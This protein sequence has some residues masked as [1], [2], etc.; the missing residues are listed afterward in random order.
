M[1]SHRQQQISRVEFWN[2]IKPDPN[3]I[4]GLGRGAQGFT[5]RSDI[6]PSKF[7]PTVSQSAPKEEDPAAHQEFDQF[8]GNDAGAF[9]YGDYDEEDKEADQVYAQIENV[10][11][12]RRKAQREKREEEESAKFRKENPL[13]AEQF[14][15]LKR[16]LADVTE[17]EW[18]AIPEI[19]DYTIKRRKRFET[20]S[21]NSDSALAGALA[22]ATG[23]AGTAVAGTESG[24]SVTDLT[25]LG[26]GRK[27][28]LG[29]NLDRMADSVSGQT[30]V[31]PTGYLTSLNSKKVSSSAEISD[32]KRARTLL[33]SM[34][35]SNPKQAHGW[36]AYARVEE[37]AGNLKSARA[38]IAEGTEACPQNEDVWLEAARLQTPEQVRSVLAR[39]VQTLPHSVKLWR[40]AAREEPDTAGKQRVL[41]KALERNSSSVGLWKALVELHDE[42]EAR[43]LLARAVECCPDQV[44]LRVALVRLEPDF[45]QAKK[46]LNRAVKELPTEPVLHII[47]AKLQEAQGTNPGMVHRIIAR[48]IKDK[49]PKAGVIIDRETWLREAE[50]AEQATPPMVQTCRAIVRE[51]VDVAVD[52]HDRKDTYHRDAAEAA[53]RGCVE[54]ARAILEHA[55]EAFPSSE[56]TWR[57]A[58]DLEKR[59]GTFETLQAV[60][61]KSVE[62]CPDSVVL[63]LMFAKEYWLA[64]NVPAARTTLEAA[65]RHN[66]ESEQ[67]MLAAYKV[68]FENGEPERARALALRAKEVLPEPSA[69]VWMK[70]AIAAREL[71][72]TK[73]Q[74]ELLEEG[75]EKFGDAPKLHMM[76]GQLEEA[77]GAPDAARRALQAGLKASPKSVPLWTMLARLEERQGNVPTARAILEQ[78]RLR[79][80]KSPALWRTAVRTELRA[81]NDAAAEAALVRGLQDCKDVSG[82]GGVGSLWAMYIG[83]APRAQR[84]GRMA[85]CVRQTDDSADVFAAFGAQFAADRK[86]DHARRYFRR[87]TAV[88]GDLGDVWGAWIAAE[89][90]DGK[91]EGAVGVLAAAAKTDP[92]H[93]ER[94]CQIRKDPL[95][96]HK[97]FEA[98]MK[99]L[100]V[101]LQTRDDKEV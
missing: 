54:T 41:R 22:T 99:L 81:G 40:Q 90:A 32:V 89:T 96:A 97:P 56:T 63:W 65:H 62:A 4:P 77:A 6:G 70:A 73:E 26:Q 17:D 50:T 46:V 8:L 82:S 16:G 57:A 51:V 78:A 84:K 12:E 47:A 35:V 88:D 67:V 53:D 79:V 49:L 13:I 74:R 10:M 7:T 37:I 15:D 20:F 55:C 33:K 44:D 61:G 24:G 19:G 31:D 39:A 2:S 48:A 86:Y 60:L 38:I 94:W 83:L 66:P 91:P 1:A 75:I 69:R 64:G 5:T 21:A 30:T 3:Y 58:A 25:A 52:E 85:E 42:A 76:L 23:N 100:V 72:H 98:L 27:Q 45:T 11:D 14:A 101:D 29:V 93:G 9:A 36:I 43:A 80:P 71:G 28:M 34:V 87:A 18:K 68:E 59:L 92:H 95:N